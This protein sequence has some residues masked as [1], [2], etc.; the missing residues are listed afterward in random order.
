MKIAVIGGGA[1]GMC[2]AITA[3]ELGGDVTLYERNERCGRKLGITGKGRCNVTN[4]CTRDEFLA[5]VPRN[6]RFM[7]AAFSRFSPQDVMSWIS[8]MGVPLKVERGRRVFP[9]S[10]RAGDVVMALVRRMRA[11]GVRE[12]HARVNDIISEPS[13][14]FRV[15]SGSHETGF[16]R[17]ILATGGCSYTGT[18]SSGDGYEFARRIG[19]SIVEPRPSLVPLVSPGRLCPSMQG[20]SLK[21]VALTVLECESG[22]RLYNDFGEMMFTHFGMTGPMVLSASAHMQDIAPGKYEI[23]IDLKPALDA[24]TLDARLLSDFSK[25]I[26]RDLENAISGLLP[27]K[28]IGPFIVKCGIDPKKKI[29]SVTRTERAAIAA[30]LKD[31]RV[32][33]SGTRPIEEAIVTSGGVDIREISP[34]TMESKLCTGLYLAG[35]LIDVDAFTGGYNLQ[36][37]WS[38]GRLA[39]ESAVSD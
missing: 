28:M 7:Y 1:A 2:A 33:V 20:L 39:G 31:F 14:G 8:E 29:N 25:N 34:K 30:C 4:D 24:Q 27:Q 26:N 21:N 18:G 3:A 12:I 19:H 15:V 6:P 35:E 13:G 9:V 17:V 5:N 10:D 36:I 11:L 37:A 23:S 32:P 38:T 16:N 22:R